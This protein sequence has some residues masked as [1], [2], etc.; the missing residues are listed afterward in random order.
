[1]IVDLPNTSTGAVSRRL[2]QL[3]ADTGAMALSRV[4]T[5]VV[6]TEETDAEDAVEVA[7]D[8][9]RQHP[10]RIIVVVTGNRRGA[11]RLDGQIRVGGDAGASE[12]VVLRLYGP[13]AAHGRAVVTP[14]LL[15]DSPIVAWWPGDAPK[16]PSA[17]PI[18]AMAQR[19]VT[20]SAH[21]EGRPRAVLKR[22]A[23]AYRPGDTDLAWSRVT[24]WR[25]L[26]AAAL[27]QPPFEPVTEATVVAAPESPSGELLAG[28][29][30]AR[31]RCP[32]SLARSRRGTGIISVRLERASGT[33]D[34][35][36][37]E[38]GNTSTLSQPGQPDRTLALQHRSDAECLADELRRLDPDE[39]YEEALTTGLAAVRASRRTASEAVRAGDAPSPS[40]AAK[41][42]RRLRRAARAAGTS[43]MVEK[44]PMP[45]DDAS[46]EQVQ[47][48]A[49]ERLA[50][51][52]ERRS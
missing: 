1:M 14:L 4:L 8:A 37:P 18:G 16:D 52:T 3:R 45:A 48:A 47:Q 35:V 22:L 30:A 44:M 36:R 20:D 2:V 50:E 23:A 15:A 41:T 38:D 46:G 32:V 31:L 28:W 12:V 7:N 34:L 43:A 51:I 49:A 39:V 42:S 10:C 11:A 24:L 21:T 29:L 5:L 27:D 19:R 17:D 40:E 9:S 26:L 25:A 6:V 33:V 13:L